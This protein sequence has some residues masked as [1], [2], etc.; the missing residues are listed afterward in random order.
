[1][2][3]KLIFL[4]SYKLYNLSEDE[5]ENVGGTGPVIKWLRLALSEAHKS[6]D[7]VHCLTWGRKQIQEHSFLGLTLWKPLKFNPC[8]GRNMSPPSSGSKNKWRKIW[9]LLDSWWF[10]GLFFDAEDGGEVLSV[11]SQ[12]NTQRH[13]PEGRT[14]HNHCCENSKSKQIQFPKHRTFYRILGDGQSK[15]Q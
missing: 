9:L 5:G 3:I 11:E 10:L 13:I 14:L 12:R 6:A 4:V 7:T 1:M 2:L 8:F 15:T